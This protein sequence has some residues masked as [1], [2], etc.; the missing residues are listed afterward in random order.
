MNKKIFVLGA[1]G[2]LGRYIYLYLKRKGYHVIGVTRKELLIGT[3]EPLCH[4]SD[5]LD[6]S[7][8]IGGDIVI[9]C[10]GVI[11]QR[12]NPD[13]G[14]TIMVNACLPHML[15]TICEDIGAQLIHITTDCVFSGQTGRYTED[16]PHDEPSLYGRTK[17][18]GEPPNA[19]VIRTSIIGEEIDNKLSLLEWAKSQKDMTVNGY[20]DHIFGGVTCLQLAKYIESLIFD[21]IYWKGVHHYTPTHSWYNDVSKY[22]GVCNVSVQKYNLLQMIN[23]VYNL[24]LTIKLYRT[25]MVDRSL[26]SKYEIPP[27]P[28]I[29]EQLIEQKEFDIYE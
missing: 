29:L 4:I 23:E 16:S 6:S 28:T 3:H 26:S 27:T 17:S 24:N 11:P 20:F 5:T 15:Q 22:D 25:P 8:I 14:L 19:C 18:L 2:M 10:I 1:N 13:M 9:N 7:G 12:K 21:G